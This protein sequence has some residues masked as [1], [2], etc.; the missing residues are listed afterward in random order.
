MELAQLGRAK[1]RQCDPQ[2]FVPWELD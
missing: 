1:V 2:S